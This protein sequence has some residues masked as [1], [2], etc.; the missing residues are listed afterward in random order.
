MVREVTY[1]LSIRTDR[2][3]RK[4][5]IGS[6]KNFLQSVNCI[7]LVGL[8]IFSWQ[9]SIDRVCRFNEMTRI[10]K[11]VYL[12]RCSRFIAGFFLAKC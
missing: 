5:S 10:A 7:S 8:R 4:S 2:T 9:Q 1:G 11:L 12:K 3:G 6:V